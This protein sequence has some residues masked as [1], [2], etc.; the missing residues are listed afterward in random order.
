MKKKPPVIEKDEYERLVEEGDNFLLNGFYV[1]NKN[2]DEDD[3]MIDDPIDY[4]AEPMEMNQCC[5]GNCN[6]GRLCPLR[7][8]RQRK[9]I[10]DY[11]V[12]WWIWGMFAVVILFAIAIW[13]A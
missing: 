13:N 1:S 9:T 10:D 6:Q 11:P 2:R 3:G 4:G 5:N 7:H 8:Q 12:D